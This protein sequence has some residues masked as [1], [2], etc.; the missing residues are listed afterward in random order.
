M[1]GTSGRTF[2]ISI[3]ISLIGVGTTRTLRHPSNDLVSD[4]TSWPACCSRRFT[5]T[6]WHFASLIRTRTGLPS[7]RTTAWFMRYAYSGY[8]RMEV[9]LPATSRWQTASR[10]ALMALGQIGNGIHS[11]GTERRS[12]PKR[13][14]AGSLNA[15]CSGADL[16]PMAQRRQKMFFKIR[17]TPAL[18][19]GILVSYYS[20]WY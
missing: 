19:T 8:W 3:R 4:S 10:V 16:L 18:L 11:V 13:L 5:I 2:Q 7:V 15:W 1:T 17:K 20:S 14:N 9:I 12:W 6:A